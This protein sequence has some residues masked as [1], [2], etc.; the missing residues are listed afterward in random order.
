M[1]KLLRSL[2]IIALAGLAMPAMSADQ[3]A[4]PAGAAVPTAPIATVNGVAIPQ[5]YADVVREDMARNN[6][7]LSDE[8]VQNI[9]VNNEV[10]AQEAIKLGL[11]KPASVQAL[12]DLQRKDI[13]GK[14]LVQ[15]FTKTHTISDER[16]QSEYDQFKA[17]VGDAQYHV[18]H[19]LVD[20]EKLAQ[21]IIQKLEAKK[22][23]K[24][25]DLAKKY[26]KDPGSAAKGGDIGWMTPVDLVPEFAEAM[27]KLKKDE[28]TM[29]PVKTRFGWHVIQ[30]L[31]TRKLEL[32]SLEQ[33]K[34]RIS[35]K[36]MQDDVQ[37]YLADLRKEAKVELPTSTK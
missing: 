34:G 4:S 14:L 33:L 19:I 21:E 8:Q 5:L 32:P 23:S 9:L 28:I 2:L 1:N 35:Q 31:D 13:L 17:K 18:R 15:N 24:F 10:L 27:T 30:L 16:I 3:A 26:S 7:K 25:E 29:T 37:K 36:L 11:D 6:Q 22:P 20:N 12:I